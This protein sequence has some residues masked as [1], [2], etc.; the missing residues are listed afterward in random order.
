M[1][2]IAR[3]RVVL[4]NSDP[5]RA[6][7]FWLTREYVAAFKDLIPRRYRRVGAWEQ[8]LRE[9]LGPTNVEVLP[10]PHDCEDG[11]Y[12]AFWR[13]PEAYLQSSVRDN[14]S[15]FR[16]LAPED[17]DR[18]LDRLATDLETGAWS[19]RH[20]ALLAMSEADV[21]LRLVIADVI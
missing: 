9:L 17:V 13:R 11:F 4:V 7:A 14:I 20:Q 21:G 19:E 2:R 12:Q 8:E 5:D 18:S 16:R 3:H 15:V 1:R 6:D 10:V